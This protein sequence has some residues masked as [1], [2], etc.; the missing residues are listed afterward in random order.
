MFLSILSL[1]LHNPIGKPLSESCPHR[2]SNS[3]S[4]RRTRLARFVTSTPEER[5]VVAQWPIILF[6]PTPSRVIPPRPLSRKIDPDES[7]V[8]TIQ[9]TMMTMM[10]TTTKVAQLVEVCFDFPP[11]TFFLNFYRRHF[12]FTF[13]LCLAFFWRT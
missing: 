12:T 13:F 1:K 11:G 6:Q 8:G 5:V 9:T 2:F 4:T 7:I 3:A 10:I